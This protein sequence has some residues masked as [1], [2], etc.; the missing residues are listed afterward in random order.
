MDVGDVATLTVSIKNTGIAETTQQLDALG[1]KGDATA[2]KFTAAFQQSSAS[3]MDFARAGASANQIAQLMGTSMTAARDA[4]ARFGGQAAETAGEV[5]GLALAEQEMAAAGLG[6]ASANN[7][8]T[9]SF[10]LANAGLGRIR[11]GMTSLV[12][13]ATGTIPVLDR[14]GGSLL[15]GFGVGLPT[16]IAVLAGIA[17]VSFAWKAM[18]SDADKLAD[19]VRAAMKKVT[20]ESLNAQLAMGDLQLGL[21]EKAAAAA[22]RVL[23]LAQSGTFEGASAKTGI[24]SVNAN[25]VANAKKVYD[26]A[27][28]DLDRWRANKTSI[29]YQIRA[30]SQQNA[31]DTLVLD[32]TSNHLVEGERQRALALYEK[33]L[34]E[35]DALG[36][37]QVD[38]VRRQ[39]LIT[40]SIALQ[41]AL[42][43]KSS[44]NP[45]P[46]LNEDVGPVKALEQAWDKQLEAMR[47]VNAESNISLNHS[48]DLTQQ[49]GLQG[50]ALALLKNQQDASDQVD[51]AHATL[52]GNA[53]TQ[54]LA[55]IEQVR[56]EADARIKATQALNDQRAAQALLNT[57]MPGVIAIGQENAKL[58]AATTDSYATLS[59]QMGSDLVRAIGQATQGGTITF[60]SFFH[61][62]ESGSSHL[63]QQVESDLDGMTR[64]HAEALA[65]MAADKS[66]ADRQ[67]DQSQAAKYAKDIEQYKQYLNVIQGLGAALAG[68]SVGYAIGQSTGSPAG[69]IV[70]GA[71]AGALAGN[72]VLPGGWGAVIG[73]LAGAAGGLLGASDAQHKAAADL[74]NAA[75]A[76]KPQLAAYTNSNATSQAQAQ[77]DATFTTLL[78]ALNALVSGNNYDAVGGL[79]AYYKQVEK[80]YQTHE[81]NA[82]D[83]TQSFWDSITQG[84]DQVTGASG[85]YDAQVAAI[86]KQYQS[87]IATALVLGATQAQLSQIE[88]ERTLQLQALAK[89]Q[90]DAIDATI[91]GYNARGLAALQATGDLPQSIKDLLFYGQQSAELLKAVNE[92]QTAAEITALKSAQALEAGAYEAKKQTDLLNAQ[93]ATATTALQTNQQQLD[94]QRQVITGVQQTIKAVQ[95]T[96]DS[97]ALN[98]GLTILSPSQQLDEARRQFQALVAQAMGGDQ[99][100]AGNLPGAAQTYLQA[101]R[102]YNNSGVGF[103]QDYTSVQA[104]LAGVQD[105][106]VAQLT[107]EQQILAVL[108]AQN[109]KLTQQIILLN[110]SLQQL[111]KQNTTYVVGSI[112]DPHFMQENAPWYF[113][114]GGPG[115]TGASGGMPSAVNNTVSPV[116]DTSGMNDIPDGTIDASGTHAW[117]ATNHTWGPIPGFASG[118][119]FAGGIMRV[120][121]DEVVATGAARVYT[122]QQLA[123]GGSD[124]VT[125][126][127][128]LRAE[129][130]AMREQQSLDTR[131]HARTVRQI[132]ATQPATRII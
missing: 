38:N 35:I 27:Q 101:S 21:A 76:L 43:P 30:E 80:L 33:D 58:I 37:T 60:A 8:A 22:Q 99:T 29:D 39:A 31:T 105:H 94:A 129:V 91:A 11:Q 14:V 17:A 96:R 114:P 28:A 66:E 84:I 10:D 83:I 115:Y 122:P 18:E 100:A 6:V 45:I 13:Q 47:R 32:I 123:A 87:N 24:A 65:K 42:Y 128:A 108:Q 78:T 90:Q 52:I 51:I 85:A 56:Q 124:V 125:E 63:L 97:L 121:R 57:L 49:I 95:A 119:D 2:S 53:L 41:N 19:K 69:G 20:D 93:L 26:Q 15:A 74:Q 82:A 59:K 111:I 127:R 12:A 1:A 62:A 102:S 4:V 55:V 36:K 5:R 131:G 67:Y 103:E 92:G 7:T 106:F 81:K 25:D 23:A 9:T 86:E 126:L 109:D 70:G 98:T 61:A 107:T 72:E 113:L 34:A 110:L 48:R 64:K 68:G 3:A 120:H 75:N 46:I 77:N 54:R 44:A 132:A 40:Q 50:E 89:A 71:A 16:M 73:G 117:N 116:A 118:G 130:K 112:Q 79:Q 104:A 88:E